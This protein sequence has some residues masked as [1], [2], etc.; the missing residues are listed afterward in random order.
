MRTA[1]LKLMS[2]AVEVD[3]EKSRIRVEKSIA[4]EGNA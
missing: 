1:C 3:A 2:N 4:V